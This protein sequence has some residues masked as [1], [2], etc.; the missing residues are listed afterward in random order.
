LNQKISYI[1]LYKYCN[2]VDELKDRIE[3]LQSE[4][5][6]LRER[7]GEIQLATDQRIEKLELLLQK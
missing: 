4:N 1:S 3:D 6:L 2:E 7:N 5:D